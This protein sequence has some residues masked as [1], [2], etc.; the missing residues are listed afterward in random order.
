MSPAVHFAPQDLFGAG[1]RKGCHLFPQLLAGTGD[2]LLDF[3]LGCHLLTVGFGLGSGLG[4]LDQLGATLFR[5][6]NDFRRS[7]AS[8]VDG[9]IR[10]LGGLLKRVA[11]LLGCRQTVSNLLLT[12][13]NGAQHG[14]PDELDREPDEERERRS[15]CE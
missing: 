2:F 6:G 8:L 15:L 11:T 9:H 7:A 5:L 12:R 10:L 3:R 13:F 1:N 4:F 14:R